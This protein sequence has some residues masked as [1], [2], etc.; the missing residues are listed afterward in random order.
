LYPDNQTL[1][2]G[3]AEALLRGEQ[4]AKVVQLLENHGRFRT[5]DAPLYR[6]LAEAYQQTG[7]P[8]DANS[9][10]AEYHYQ[11]GSLEAAIQ[12]LR[13]ALNIPGGSFYQT[14]RLEARLKQLENE[15]ALQEEK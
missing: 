1:I 15:K 8:K 13:L 10:L 4:P 9:A 12:Q 11:N 5:L 7:N 14:S 3:Y 2:L 6:L